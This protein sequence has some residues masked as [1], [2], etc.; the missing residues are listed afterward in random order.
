MDSTGHVLAPTK[1]GKP[2][3]LVPV[4]HSLSLPL[5]RAEE[6]RKACEGPAARFRIIQRCSLPTPRVHTDRYTELNSCQDGK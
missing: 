5:S 1:D 3:R 2:V 6:T 4:R